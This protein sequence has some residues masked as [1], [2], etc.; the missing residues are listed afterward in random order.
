MDK[1]KRRIEDLEKQNCLRKEQKEELQLQ[2]ENY[3]GA[4]NKFEKV[5]NKFKHTFIKDEE[6]EQIANEK[7][8]ENSFEG[9]LLKEL[10]IIRRNNNAMTR[11][12]RDLKVVTKLKRES[13]ETEEEKNMRLMF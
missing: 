12:I 7:V 9:G 1:T 4:L 6:L 3:G 10:D 11:K 8:E 5:E 2:K 13:I